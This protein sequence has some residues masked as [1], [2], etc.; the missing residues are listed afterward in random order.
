M[1]QEFWQELKRLIMPPRATSVTAE[2]TSALAEINASN[3][4]FDLKDIVGRCEDKW[5]VITITRHT[6]KTFSGKWDCTLGD[7]KMEIWDDED[8]G[9]GKELFTCKTSERGGPA[10]DDFHYKD[11]N[12][13]RYMI[14]ARETYGLAAWAGER[15]KTY[16]HCSRQ[17]L[18]TNWKTIPRPGISVYGNRAG[19]MDLRTAIVMHCGSSHG[20]SKG[21]VVLYRGN[22]TESA[23]R[24]RFDLGQSYD[25]VVQ[26]LQIRYLTTR[27]K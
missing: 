1:S 16:G 6:K 11:N 26:Y 27:R 20:W 15:Y 25:T 3:D 21:C 2:V 24:V 5:L 9:V 8:S 13:E 10:H 4:L 14:I 19:A 12:T 23:G 22:E 7:L 18:V 17:S